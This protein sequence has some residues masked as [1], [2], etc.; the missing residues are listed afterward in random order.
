MKDKKTKRVGIRLSEMAF[1]KLMAICG[2][3]SKTVTNIIED[4]IETEYR[5]DSRYWDW[6]IGKNDGKM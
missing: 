6:K 2:V 4:F 1:K 3:N 5:K